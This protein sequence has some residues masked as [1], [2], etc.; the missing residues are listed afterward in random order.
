MAGFEVIMY[1]RFWVSTEVLHAIH[2]NSRNPAALGFGTRL[3]LL[4]VAAIRRERRLFLTR[5]VNGG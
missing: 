2:D 4:W 3:R 1:G 5:S